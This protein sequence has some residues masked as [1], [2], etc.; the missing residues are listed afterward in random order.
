[1]PRQTPILLAVDQFVVPAGR[2]VKRI[3]SYELGWKMD[4]LDKHLR[5][6]LTL[7]NTEAL[8]PNTNL[9]QCGAGMVPPGCLNYDPHTLSPSGSENPTLFEL[10]SIVYLQ[11]FG[12]WNANL[13]SLRP[14]PTPTTNSWVIRDSK[15]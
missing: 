9:P 1:L 8:P 3:A 6:I 4:L 12:L 5:A 7:I 13:D 15:V 2:E 14:V 10:P 11:S